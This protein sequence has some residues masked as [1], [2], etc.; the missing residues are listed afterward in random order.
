MKRLQNRRTSIS[1]ILLLAIT[2][3]AK[4]AYL[5]AKIGPQ[6]DSVNAVK[7]AAGM[8]LVAKRS[9]KGPY[10]R[11]TVVYL[12][13][14]GNNGTLGLIVNRPSKLTLAQGVANID[15]ED[16]QDHPLYFGGP[17]GV[18]Q[19]LMLLRNPPDLPSIEHVADNV[20]VSFARV[21]LD[22]V[23][24]SEKPDNEIR[25]YIGHAG[26]TAGQL[27]FEIAR[28]SWHLIRGDTETIFSDDTVSLWERLIDRLEPV[29][30]HVKRKSQHPANTDIL[31]DF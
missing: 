9:L 11:R 13:E 8:F 3:V 12:V 15:E 14:H 5:P 21:V 28:G 23:L 7:P 22:Q 16:G 20:Y 29:G 31:S 26:W 17:V 10:F 24:E 18:S 25:F 2:V 6:S 1:L 19:V 27:D 30:I 4:G